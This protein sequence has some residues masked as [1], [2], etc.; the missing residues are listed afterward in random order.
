MIDN[1]IDYSRV[2]SIDEFIAL[3]KGGTLTDRQAYGIYTNKHGHV[4]SLQL[5]P[6]NARK[7][8][9]DSRFRFVYCII[10]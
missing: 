7:G 4:T 5:L 10:K 1:S 2:M 8:I 3:S 6:S 9:Y